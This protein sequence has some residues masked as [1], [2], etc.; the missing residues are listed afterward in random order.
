MAKF[1][2]TIGAIASVL[3]SAIMITSV[4]VS[5]SALE[6]DNITTAQ[7]VIDSSSPAEDNLSNAE[8]A[9]GEVVEI[10]MSYK[11]GAPCYKYS[12]NITPGDVNFDGKIDIHDAILVQQYLAGIIDL[13]DSQVIAADFNV[14]GLVTIADV[15]KLQFS[16]AELD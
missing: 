3:M 1:R 7:D 6:A 10:R 13:T 16:L 2:K 8:K 14:D 9:S 11:T 12:Q 15:L 4:Q 5:V